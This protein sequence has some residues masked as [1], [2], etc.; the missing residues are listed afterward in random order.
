ML[1]P[2]ND[3]EDPDAAEGGGHWSLLVFRRHGQEGGAAR[4]EYY[5]SL[6]ASNLAHAKRVAATLAPLLLPAAMAYGIDPIHFGIIMVVNLEIGY[7]TP[8]IG[9]NL[10]VA[11]TAFKEPFLLI[12]RA[13]VPF[14]LLML[15]VLALVVWLP[16]LSLMLIR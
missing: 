14:I 7:L 15:G 8:P 9:L 2:V 5:D 4:F 11:M 6:L 3:N 16:E 12:C 1:I 13:V 10:I